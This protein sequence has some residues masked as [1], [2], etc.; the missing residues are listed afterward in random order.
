MVSCLYSRLG[1]VS[2]EDG[3][4]NV[5][6]RFHNGTL[7]KK[8]NMYKIPLIDQLFILFITTIYI[9]YILHYQ[10]LLYCWIGDKKLQKITSTAN[11]PSMFEVL[12]DH[13]E[14]K[15]KPTRKPNQ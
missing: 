8:K 15:R 14:L 12:C 10:V 6:L 7:I 2:D 5:I 4:Q 13:Q 9:L 1:R 11:N 3:L